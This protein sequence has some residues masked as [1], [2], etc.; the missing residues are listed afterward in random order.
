MAT[1]NF[2]PP[3][4]LQPTDR[5]SSPPPANGTSI[6]DFCTEYRLGDEVLDGLTALKFQMGDDHREI[7]PESLSEVN[8]AQHHWKR[9][10]KAYS[11]YKHANK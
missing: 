5:C 11:K 7:T 2:Y 6:I 4:H 3:P 1:P 8:F 9:F 10:C